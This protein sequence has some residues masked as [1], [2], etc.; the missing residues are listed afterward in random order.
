MSV[1]GFH[2]GSVAQLTLQCWILS[3]LRF[4]Y[5]V[6]NVCSV[7]FFMWSACP[8]KRAMRSTLH[9]FGVLSL[10]SPALNVL[11]W[12]YTELF[13][14]FFD[15]HALSLCFG[16]QACM[17]N[18]QWFLIWLYSG[19][20]LLSCIT[21]KLMEKKCKLNSSDVFTNKL[22]LSWHTNGCLWRCIFTKAI[23]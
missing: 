11:V 1:L 3:P 23:Y 10:V 4:F 21:W 7:Y 13:F 19:T 22:C 17:K 6:K 5:S 8:I 14:V 18:E 20:N 2:S 12:D 15:A 16:I 9:C